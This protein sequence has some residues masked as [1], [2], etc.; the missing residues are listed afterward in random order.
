MTE[1]TTPQQDAQ[2]PTEAPQPTNLYTR[3]PIQVEAR[4]FFRYN[5]RELADWCLG[6]F[7]YRTA[8]LRKET[9]RL[10]VPGH[11]EIDEGFWV[12]KESNGMFTALSDVDFEEMF[13]PVYPSPTGD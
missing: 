1:Q 13:T 11:G 9:V 4:Q 6:E 7:Y 8:P 2:D 10:L 5:G 3:N 12:I